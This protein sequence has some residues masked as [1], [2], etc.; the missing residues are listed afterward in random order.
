MLIKAVA[1]SKYADK[2]QLILAGDGPLK[3]KL[4]A[5]AARTLKHQPVFRFFGRD[6]MVDTINSADLYVHPAEIEIES[7]A[8]L[9]AIT[10]GL[11]PVISNSDRSAA[12][13]FALREDNLFE[14]GNAENLAKK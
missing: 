4:E 1:L 2:I 13:Y 7:I 3:S 10:C 9:E 8:C 12:R 11:V 14:A 6:E 5:L